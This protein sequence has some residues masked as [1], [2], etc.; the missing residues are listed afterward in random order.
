M[1]SALLLVGLA[2]RG[3]AQGDLGRLA[4]QPFFNTPQDTIQHILSPLVPSNRRTNFSFGSDSWDTSATSPR[5]NAS[6]P[7]RGRP[8]P[9]RCDNSPRLGEFVP[10]AMD[11]KVSRDTSNRNATFTQMI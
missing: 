10:R 2:V 8:R 4:Q 11:Y 5:S 6:A 3:M 1:S 9:L 7:D